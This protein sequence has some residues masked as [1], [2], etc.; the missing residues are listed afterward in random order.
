MNPI[1]DSTHDYLYTALGVCIGFLM[2]HYFGWTKGW[3]D[4]K[5]DA[6]DKEGVQD[7]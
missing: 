5:K 7:E 2:G 4:C 6:E 3:R 1:F